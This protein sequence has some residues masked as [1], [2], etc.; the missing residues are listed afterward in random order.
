METKYKVVRFYF[1]GREPQVV[2]QNLTKDEAIE[3]CN[4]PETSS[5]TATNPNAVEYTKIN[6]D[7]FDGW[8]VDDE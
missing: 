4:D 3:W 6:G 2:R 7:W 5:S 8:T 1:K